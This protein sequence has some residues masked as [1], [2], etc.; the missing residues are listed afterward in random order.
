M[1]PRKSTAE[2]TLTFCTD[3]PKPCFVMTLIEFTECTVWSR[4]CWMHAGFLRWIY[5]PQRESSQHRVSFFHPSSPPV[6][7]HERSQQRGIVAQTKTYLPMSLL[8]I[9][10]SKSHDYEMW[11]EK[12][13]PHQPITQYHH[14]RTGEDNAELISSVRSW[15]GKSLLP[16]QK[17][18]SILAPGNRSST[19]SS[20]AEERSEC[21]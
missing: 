13:A 11:L 12:L 20:T 8:P 21:W 5:N 15:D 1:V 6:R 14:N 9:Q 18:N 3:C 7:L 4:R 19:A 10:F 2:K 16:S 17:A